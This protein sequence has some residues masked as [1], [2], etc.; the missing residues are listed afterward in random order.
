MGESNES[1]ITE[2]GDVISQ[3]FVLDQPNLEDLIEVIEE[4]VDYRGDITL[5]LKDNS[6][7]TGYIFSSDLKGEDS[8]LS[9][10]PKGEDERV[11]ILLA[12]ITKLHF[13]GRDTASGKSWE[14]WVKNYNEKKAARARGEDVGL[15]GIEAESLDDE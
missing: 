14:T 11:S 9:L 13:S 7:V 15:I 4:V 3:G 8:T 10:F 5:H 1:E 6:E 2:Q 12:D